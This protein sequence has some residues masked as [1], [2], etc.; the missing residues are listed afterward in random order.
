MKF[1]V[2]KI[3]ILVIDYVIFVFYDHGLTMEDID[4]GILENDFFY[5]NQ[6]V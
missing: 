5:I 6:C 1:S 3:Y 2:A 4:F